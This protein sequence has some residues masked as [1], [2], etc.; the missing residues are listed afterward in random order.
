V[1]RC[2]D[3][4][5]VTK[6]NARVTERIL[7]VVGNVVTEIFKEESMRTRSILVS[8]VVVLFLL[9]VGPVFA[10]GGQG[11]TGGA[12][13]IDFVNWVTAE[14]STR[15]PVDDIIEDFESANPDIDVNPVPV[16]FS[17]I[18]NQL[19]VMYNSG[20]SPDLAQA[21]GPNI[22]ILALMG[23]L[24]SADEVFPRDFQNDLVKSAYDLTMVEGTH[25]GIPWAPGPDG[26]FFNKDLMRQA[27]LDPNNPPETIYDFQ[28]QIAKARGPLPS[29]IVVFGFDTTVR[30]FGFEMTYPFLR[31]FGA[32]PFQGDPANFNTP[33][34]KEYMQWMRTSVEK[35]HTLPGKKIGEFRPIA[36]QGRLLFMIDPS[37]VKGIV[38]SINDQLT[39]EQ[40]NKSWGVAAL[41]GDKNGKHYTYASDH[42]LCVFEESQHKDAAA[43]LAMHLVNSD[44]ALRNY[45]L[46]IGYTPATKSALD[47][48]PE[49]REDPIIKAFV[50]NVNDTVVKIPYGPDYGDI[51]IPFMAGVQEVITT[52]KSIDE[53]LD[54]V[55]EQIENIK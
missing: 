34:V 30:M 47:R 54:G 25:Y 22:T 35:K 42:Q 51:V 33:E 10:G 23:A 6:I 46:K 44:Y 38:L 26:L 5:K 40:F 28:D 7:H 13:T 45:L 50:E 41:P 19:T 32:T 55:Q 20:D 18:L 53:V 39:E 4:A 49:F 12:V 9:S 24:A 15:T 16:G 31:A 11:E 21:A 3:F 37:F 14:E 17:D 27:G 29:E 48:V 36:A 43:K 2:I 52:D 1:I 8:I